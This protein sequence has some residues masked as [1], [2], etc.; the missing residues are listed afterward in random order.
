MVYPR[1]DTHPYTFAADY[2]L[3]FFLQRCH[4]LLSPSETSEQV[5]VDLLLKATRGSL[6]A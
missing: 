6:I 1:T 4:S 3:P 2:I 5:A